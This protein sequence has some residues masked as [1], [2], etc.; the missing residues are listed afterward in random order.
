MRRGLK[1]GIGVASVLLAA[2]LLAGCGHVKS[3]KELLRHA[4][5][6]HGK[7]KVVSQSEEPE[8]VT[9]VLRDEKQGFEYT[10][11]SYMSSFN[12]DGASF[13]TFPETRDGFDEALF[14]YT[15]EQ[16]KEELDALL[17]SSGSRFNKDGLTLTLK[18]SAD[19]KQLCEAA[20]QIF[21][22]HNVDHRLD[23]YNIGVNN[24]KGEHL[25]SCTL[26][27]CS[28]RVPEEEKE[29]FFL[30]QAGILME[31]YP[32][33]RR[34]VEFVRK[35]DKTFKDTGLEPERAGCG[36]DTDKSPEKDSD[37]VTYYYFRTE[38]QEFFIADFEDVSTGL[39]Y[40]DFDPEKEKK[41]K[42]FFNISINI[43]NTKK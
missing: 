17:K 10:V 38:N 18:G 8:S 32:E 5:A 40:T 13:G 37:P 33:K 36:Y 27:A 29:D 15:C 26:P 6:N 20:A 23:G 43:R 7:C 41:S 25:G 11:K 1:K 3:A 19:E 30:S 42:G 14:E 2:A 4:R 22:K 24:E 35:E 28:F 12:L 31:P 21:Q 34:G 39:W 9:V 16:T